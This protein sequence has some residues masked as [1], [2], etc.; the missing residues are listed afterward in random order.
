VSAALPAGAHQQL[1]RF[2]TVEKRLTLEQFEVIRR[3]PL[4][5]HYQ[6]A[7]ILTNPLP[8]LGGSLILFT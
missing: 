4:R 7:Q 8:S 2:T 3:S 6:G 5:C 1:C